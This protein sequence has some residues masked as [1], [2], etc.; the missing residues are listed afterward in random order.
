[1]TKEYCHMTKEYCHMTKHR[2]MTN[3]YCHMIYHI[4]D[5]KGVAG[6]EDLGQ[7][8]KE[9]LNNRTSFHT[10]YLV[11]PTIWFTRKYLILFS[12]F[13]PLSLP[14]LSSCSPTLLDARRDG[15]WGV[16]ARREEE[17]GIQ[18]GYHDGTVSQVSYI[19]VGTMTAQFHRLVTL[20]WVP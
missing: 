12:A 6:L 8:L 1:M 14:S 19:K 10:A 4:L 20:R 16:Q 7:K 17:D 5:V 13:L 3:D 9:I 11:R 2:H 15:D 18:S